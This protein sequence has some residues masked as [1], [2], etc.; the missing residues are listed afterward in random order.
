M[1][2]ELGEALAFGLA[3]GA[4]AEAA[5]LASAHRHAFGIGV[6]RADDGQRHGKWVV[7]EALRGFREHQAGLLD[8]IGAFGYSLLR[9]PSNTL[10]PSIL[11]PRR[12]PALPDTP[13]TLSKWS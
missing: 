10:P 12:L 1:M 7:A 3:S 2:V 8:L 4:V 9:G 5:I 6:G 13:Q 11:L